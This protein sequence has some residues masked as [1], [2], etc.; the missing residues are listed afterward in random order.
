MKVHEFQAKQLLRRHQIPIPEGDVA[1]T[2]AEARAVAEKLGGDRFVVKAQVHAGGRGKGGGIKL[3]SSPAEVEQ[4]AGEIIGMTLVTPQTGADGRLVRSVLIEQ[5]VDIADELYLGVVVDRERGKVAVMA[6]R[7][8]GMEIEEVAA[9]QPDAITTAFVHPDLGLRPFQARRLATALGVE[10]RDQLKAAMTTITRLVD[11]FQATDASLVEIN[12]LVRTGAG[13][14]LALDAKL[15]VDDNALYRHPDIRDMR[16]LGEEAPLD[17]IEVAGTIKW[18]D[19]S[20]GYGF[21]IPD[22]GLPDVL[23]HVTCLRR[24]GFQTAYEGARVVCEAFDR[25]KVTSST[26]SSPSFWNQR[27]ASRP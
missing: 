13:D 1:T 3:G 7:E 16:D 8:G 15:N 9:S 20:K 27:A 12:P 26:G 4:L 14:L 18:F 23:L 5:G 22:N 25:P 24:G 10:G 6:S 11:L 19:A 21:I 2:A 17:L